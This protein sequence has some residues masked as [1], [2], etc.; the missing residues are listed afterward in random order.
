MHEFKEGDLVFVGSRGTNMYG[1]TV[2][3]SWGYV[4]HPDAQTEDEGSRQQDE[5]PVR[6]VGF[7]KGS[8]HHSYPKLR[9][10]RIRAEH[11]VCIHDPQGTHEEISEI[12]RVMLGLAGVEQDDGQ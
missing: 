2:P 6:F 4:L 3:G 5:V 9:C 12:V 1:I 10:W 8:D 7:G 11:L